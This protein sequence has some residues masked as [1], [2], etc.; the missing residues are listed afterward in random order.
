M[1]EVYGVVV[2]FFDSGGDGEDVWVEDD[3][4]WVEADFIYEDVV[5]ALADVD[6]VLVGG[7]LAVFIECHDD[8]CCAVFHDFT[9]V[10]A[11]GVFSF[12]E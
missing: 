8:D 5:G 9:G 7:G 12:F 10:F 11:E 4:L 1:E 3:V 6:L 2:V